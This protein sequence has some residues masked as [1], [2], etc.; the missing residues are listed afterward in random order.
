VVANFFH[1]KNLLADTEAFLRNQLS[2]L[3][4]SIDP[5]DQ[6]AV[7]ESEMRMIRYYAFFWIGGRIWAIFMLFWMT[8]PVSVGYI[9]DLSHVFRAGYLA[10]PWNF[11]DGALIATIFLTFTLAGFILWVHRLVI[12]QR[13]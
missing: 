12:R 11:I 9:R 6:S 5:I 7:P 4:P 3:V 2:R 8:I 13:S 10:N 1:C